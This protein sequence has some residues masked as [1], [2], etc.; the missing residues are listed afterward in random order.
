MTDTTT[1]PAPRQDMHPTGGGS[2]S[3][4]GFKTQPDTTEDR[5]RRRHRKAAVEHRNGIPW[6]ES[7]IPDPEHACT[8]QTSGI[9]DQKRVERCACGAVRVEIEGRTGIW[10]NR[11]THTASSATA[12]V[13]DPPETPSSET[14]LENQVEPLRDFADALRRL[15]AA[16]IKLHPHR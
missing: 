12:K 9:L 1:R 3:A 4:Q 7:P 15:T 11:N 8:T 6:Y 13:V 14:R 2:W 16:I 10:V 5:D